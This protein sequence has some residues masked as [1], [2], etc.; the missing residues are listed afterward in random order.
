MNAQALSSAQLAA[1]GR[2]TRHAKPVDTDREPLGDRI[3]RWLGNAQLSG[4]RA[5]DIR[6]GVL[7]AYELQ[8]ATEDAELQ[9]LLEA[10]QEPAAAPKR[11][12]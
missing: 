5:N 9:R 1:L 12:K 3:G 11:G 10:Q 2:I 8:K 7:L 4:V 6:R